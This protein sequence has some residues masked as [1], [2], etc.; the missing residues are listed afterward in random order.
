MCA[1]SMVHDNFHDRFPNPHEWSKTIYDDFRKKLD[2]AALEDL[3]K[4]AQD[5]VDPE[6]AKFR[7]IVEEVLREKGIIA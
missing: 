1:V 6:K 4:K 7:K 3:M 2:E 5:C